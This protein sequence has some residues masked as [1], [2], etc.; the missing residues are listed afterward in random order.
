MKLYP[1]S[2]HLLE[3]VEDIS[4]YIY[5]GKG[6]VTLL[7]PTG[8]QHTY[9][10]QKPRDSDEFPDDVRFV[11]A[12]HDNCKLFYIGMVENGEFRLTKRSRFLNDTE[13]VRGARYIWKMANMSF[14]TPMKLYHEGMCARCGRQLTS[15]HSKIHGFGKDCLRRV[16]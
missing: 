2:R 13:I 14:E 1:E 10:F 8:V 15:E 3:G 9:A 7:S 11:Y 4:R 5:G 6:V 12:V 16:K